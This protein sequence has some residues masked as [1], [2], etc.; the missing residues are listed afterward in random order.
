MADFNENQRLCI[1]QE[2]HDSDLTVTVEIKRTVIAKF[3]A[4]PNNRES[5][6]VLESVGQ[7][8]VRSV[9]HTS[10][11]GCS[12]CSDVFCQTLA[13]SNSAWNSQNYRHDNFVSTCSVWFVGGVPAISEEHAKGHVDIPQYA[14]IASECICQQNVTKFGSG[15]FGQSTYEN[16]LQSQEKTDTAG[17]GGSIEWP[18]ED[19]E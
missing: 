1:L 13:E 10:S 7:M 17:S 15:F 2:T 18:D 12:T 3:G 11:S 4:E 16:S 14:G 5:C 8:L 19:E 6:R 9:R